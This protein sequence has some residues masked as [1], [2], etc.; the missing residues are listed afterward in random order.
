MN[1]VNKYFAIFAF[2]AFS[3]SAFFFSPVNSTH[4]L[5]DNPANHTNDNVDPVPNDTYHCNSRSF[6]HHLNRDSCRNAWNKIEQSTNP[7]TFNSRP[8]GSGQHVEIPI[9]SRLPIRYLSDDGLCAIDLRLQSNSRRD[10]CNTRAIA[11]AADS[12]L[13]NC[14]ERRGW[15]GHMLVECESGLLLRQFQWVRFARALIAYFGPEILSE[16][17]GSCQSATCLY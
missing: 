4:I 11:A 2:L 3:S 16:E 15:G 1:S 7:R 9:E 14:V 6:G 5:P 10:T 17:S 13:R 8:P 12:V